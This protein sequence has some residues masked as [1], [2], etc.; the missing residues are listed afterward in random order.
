MFQTIVVEVSFSQLSIFWQGLEHPFNDWTDKHV[1]QGF[2]WRPGSVSFRT[3]VETGLHSVKI[4]FV[5][6]VESI[7]V[8]AIRAIDVPFDMPTDASIEIGSIFDSTAISL[9]AGQYLLRCEF[10]SG[11][12]P[13]RQR[14]GL[15]FANKEIP[16]FA[17][18]RADDALR[19]E[20]PLIT[21]AV[22]ASN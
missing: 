15:I 19:P 4:S 3:L 11:G 10:L 16:R 18:L 9:P 22:A 14:V 8:N 13:D 12:K 1:L 21:M 5:D 20:N 2:A 17:V 6:R 7:N